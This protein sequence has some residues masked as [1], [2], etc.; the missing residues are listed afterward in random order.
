MKQ[1]LR[2]W[3]SYG[4]KR[5]Q[6]EYFLYLQSLLKVRYILTG[7]V[8]P[9]LRKRTCTIVHYQYFTRTLPVL[10]TRSSF[11]RTFFALCSNFYRAVCVLDV[12]RMREILA[13]STRT[14]CERHARWANNGRRKAGKCM[15]MVRS[16]VAAPCSSP[17]SLVPHPC[18]IHIKPV[19]ISIKRPKNGT[20][21]RS[22]RQTI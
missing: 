4:L 19:Y 5:T 2:L 20:L 17:P 13:Y 10:E 9:M 21:P 8:A 11:P 16:V 3:A 14:V 7:Y 12:C 1:F 18:D 22:K 6:P 15:A